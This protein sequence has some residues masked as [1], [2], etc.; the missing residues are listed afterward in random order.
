MKK[1]K[2][3]LTILILLSICILIILIY[4][5]ISIYAVFHSELGAKVEFKNGIWNINV[6]GQKISTGVQTDFTI[7]QITVTE[8][9]HTMPGKIAPGLA[10]NFKILINP[11]NTNVSIRYD[12]TL[13]GEELKN[14]NVKISSVEEKANG[15]KLIKTAENV[16]TGIITLQDIEKGI[17]HEIDMEVEWVDNSQNNEID[18]KL[19][20][21][22][23]E[24]ELK[25][26]VTFH[27]VQYLGEE[28]NSI[29]NNEEQ[30]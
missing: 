9:E 3:L 19:G 26:P 30:E 10:G 12:I 25:I 24:R 4:R 8:D 18:T 5:V 13:N 29:D 21:N 1:N 6:N 16:Y 17:I 28:I 7:D 27:A 23:E 20:T 2:N 15:A 11:E 22:K 14:S